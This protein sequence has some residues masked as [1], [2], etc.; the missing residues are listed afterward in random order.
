MTLFPAKIQHQILEYTTAN[1]TWFPIQE[2]FVRKTRKTSVK[3]YKKN[4]IYFYFAFGNSHFLLEP[5]NLF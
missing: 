2:I 1:N 5:F 3:N 4:H